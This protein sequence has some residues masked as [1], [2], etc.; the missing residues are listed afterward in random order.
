MRLYIALRLAIIGVSITNRR[1]SLE[2]EHLLL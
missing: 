2:V 1:D